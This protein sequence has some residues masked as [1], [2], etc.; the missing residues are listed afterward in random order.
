MAV[1]V[2]SWKAISLPRLRDF[3]QVEQRVVFVG[4]LI[5]ALFAVLMPGAPLLFMGICT[6][7]I[8]NLMYFLQ[9]VAVRQYSIALSPGTG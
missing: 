2:N 3:L 7:T 1:N 9:T 5:S 6:L 4:V 8:G